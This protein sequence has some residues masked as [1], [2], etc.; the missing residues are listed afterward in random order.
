MTMKSV[1]LKNRGRQG[2]IDRGDVSEVAGAETGA[3][4]QVSEPQRREAHPSP[5]WRHLAGC[6]EH[7]ASRSVVTQ[8][9]AVASDGAPFIPEGLSSEG[10][11]GRCS[12]DA[13]AWSGG[14]GVVR[15]LLTSGRQLVISDVRGGTRPVVVLRAAW[16]SH[17]EIVAKYYPSDAIKLILELEFSPCLYAS[18]SPGS[19]LPDYANYNAKTTNPSRRSQ[20]PIVVIISKQLPKISLKKK[21]ESGP[22]SPCPSSKHVSSLIT[23]LCSSFICLHHRYPS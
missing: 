3:A 4:S 2:G 1:R 10:G 19:L 9:F 17:Y 18:Y 16:C 6:S 20:T 5:G 8:T 21:R 12:D 22:P 15:E 7:W 23:N 11:S 13:R 14:G